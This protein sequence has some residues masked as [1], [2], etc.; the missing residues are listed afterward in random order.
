MVRILDDTNTLDGNGDV[1]TG[2]FAHKEV[3]IVAEVPD[4]THLKLSHPLKHTYD[5]AQTARVER[6]EAL[7]DVELRNFRIS[8]A[9]QQADGQ[10][11]I[12]V[13]YAHNVVITNAHIIGGGDGGVSWSGHA[14]RFTDSLD[15]HAIGG[16]IANPSDTDAG[17]GYGVS[18]YGATNCT[19]KGLAVTGCR[20]SVLWFNGAAGCEAH[21]CVSTDARISDYD[22]HGA[23][24]G[25]NKTVSC[26]AQ[27]G[28]RRTPDS[29]HERTAW[30]WGNPSHRPGIT[31]TRRSTAS[32]WI[33][34]GPRSRSS[35][36]AR[37]TFGRASSVVRASGSRW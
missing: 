9:A 36:T 11:A 15:C 5:L 20:H 34:T 19:V 6:L 37:T 17:R 18:F 29:D 1:Q 27:G 10:H 33:T 31:R 23:D 8:F 16:A 4:A 24:C 7:K 12:E 21:G 22:W 14:I 3:A 26:T 13:R 35:R 2:N 25:R 32:S 28:T 30:K